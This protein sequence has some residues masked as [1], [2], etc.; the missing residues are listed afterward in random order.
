MKVQVLGICRFSL[1]VEGGFQVEHETLDDRRR[2][3]YD[4]ARLA[5]RFLWFEHICLPSWRVQTDPD[6]RLI[7]ATGEDFPQPW[8]DRLRKLVAD[9]PQVVIEQAPPL[10]HRPLCRQLIR[11]HIDA[12]TDIV[13]QFRQDDDD[14]VA[15]DY[16]ARLRT[17][18]KDL[19]SL[20]ATKGMIWA[21]HC[22]GFTLMTPSSG[23]DV[24]AQVAERM[25]AGLAIYMPPDAEN[26]VMNFGHH[27]LNQVMTGVSFH[28]SFMY[29]RGKH[30]L[31]DSTKGTYVHNGAR[32]RCDDPL[33]VF[34]DRFA[35]D[36]EAF[37]KARAAL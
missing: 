4:P 28:D 32:V 37:E 27:K 31:N 21:D 11:K 26:C 25:T 20:C 13:A 14:A 30:G 34:R 33:K 16:V 15:L 35:I 1:L 9:I 18:F 17:D 22:R 7:V 3:L 10:Q 2:M 12:T 6:F 29:V 8:L 36:L 23:M 19:G 5:Q 24:I